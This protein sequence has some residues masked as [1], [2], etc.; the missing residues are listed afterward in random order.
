MIDRYDEARR[1]SDHEFLALLR[2]KHR[3]AREFLSDVEVKKRIQQLIETRRASMEH[4]AIW[5]AITNIL[6]I[7]QH[8]PTS[9]FCGIAP[10]VPRLISS[11][12]QITDTQSN[13]N[14]SSN[15]RD[16]T[17]N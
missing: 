10:F 1:T 3:E 9:T 15:V 14:E 6:G 12:P 2:K 5:T 17:N 16:L 7:L 8:F 13:A 4:R 11:F